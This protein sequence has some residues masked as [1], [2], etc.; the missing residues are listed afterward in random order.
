MHTSLEPFPVAQAW[1]SSLIATLLPMLGQGTLRG[2]ALAYALWGMYRLRLVLGPDALT[3]LMTH[4]SDP[5]AGLTG[6]SEEAAVAAWAIAGLW[7]SARHTAIQD[8]GGDGRG[9][10]AAA[11]AAAGVVERRG[12]RLRLR[13]Q[14]QL[15]AAS[16]A[17]AVLEPEVE[18]LIAPIRRALGRVPLFSR[19]LGTASGTESDSEPASAAGERFTPSI[20]PAAPSKQPPLPATALHLV[21]RRKT[22]RLAV[23][24][25][26]RLARRR[27]RQRH[28]E[29]LRRCL[30]ALLLP[31]AMASAAAPPLPPKSGVSLHPTATLMSARVLALSTAAWAMP[32]RDLPPPP[33]PWLRL[34]LETV[35]ALAAV[36]AATAAAAAAAAL[37]LSGVQPLGAAAPEHP[38]PAPAW[39]SVSLL[40]T[41]AALRKLQGRARGADGCS[42]VGRG[43]DGASSWSVCDSPSW[44]LR[45][46]QA[47]ALH[48]PRLHAQQLSAMMLG[49]AAL[50][51]PATSI[52]AVGTRGL[53]AE[54]CGPIATAPAITLDVLRGTPTGGDSANSDRARGRPVWDP[55]EPATVEEVAVETEALACAVDLLAA[56]VLQRW[57]LLSAVR[58]RMLRELPPGGA[59]RDVVVVM[60]PASTPTHT[61]GLAAALVLG[62]RARRLP[63]EGAAELRRELRVALV[64]LP[65][66]GRCRSQAELALQVLEANRG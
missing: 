10:M 6:G 54:V 38:C 37:S 41:L 56:A 19:S 7:V 4:L 46:V 40:T 58:R 62:L 60:P 48:V 45:L 12:R 63:M 17:R 15:P 21:A 59:K 66:G 28:T 16:E 32:G 39:D 53:Q 25:K 13:K 24:S 14:Q 9:A 47:A 8:R 51:G 35:G 27:R 65:G 29:A 31:K 55:R 64:H 61:A 3:A 1:T 42:T 33:G 49:L 5:A 52:T 44:S 50:C 20:F 57:C 26:Q 36:E 34:V 18:V 11:A 30:M 43:K 2:R 22:P 23:S